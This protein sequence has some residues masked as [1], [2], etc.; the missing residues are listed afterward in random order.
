MSFQIRADANRGEPPTIYIHDMIGRAEGGGGGF[1]V[2]DLQQFLDANRNAREIIVEISST[3]GDAYAGL[4]IYEKLIS[5]PAKVRTRAVGIV[6]SAASI[7]FLAGDI[8]E[9]SE[10]S[11]IM[12]HN[13][14]IEAIGGVR[15]MRQAKRM[16]EQLNSKMARIVSQRTGQ[17]ESVVKAWLDEEKWFGANDAKSLG[18]ATHVSGAVQVTASLDVSRF[19]NTPHRVKQLAQTRMVAAMHSHPDRRELRQSPEALIAKYG[20]PKSLADLMSIT[21]GRAPASATV[22][23]K[24]KATTAKA[25]TSLAEVM[26]LTN[27]SKT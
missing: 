19:R 14:S 2:G 7:I 4:A 12:I 23:A 17:P 24:P 21:N 1:T 26:A 16:L 15:E 11:E 8:R 18:F 10:N 3:G 25:P 13:G 20:Q 6:A 9:A 5:S 22:K 27:K